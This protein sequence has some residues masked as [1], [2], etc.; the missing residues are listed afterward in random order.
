MTQARFVVILVVV[1]VSA[2]TSV[3]LAYVLTGSPAPIHLAVSENPI[4]GVIS[5]N[6][7]GIFSNASLVREFEA[8][9]YANQSGGPASTLTLQV[10][11]ETYDDPG[12]GVVRTLVGLTLAGHFASA[13][14]P[15]NLLLTVNDTGPAI[16]LQVDSVLVATNFTFDS[17]PYISLLQASTGSLS[18]SLTNAGSAIP[19]YQFGIQSTISGDTFEVS[20]SPQYNHFVGFRATVTGPFTPAVSVSVL[21]EIINT[22]GG[23]WA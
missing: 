14:G 19:F 11:T 6:L 13:L 7:T 16:S 10:R 12:N 5:G 23:T 9:T 20:F 2:S 3:A 22:N 4:L 8:I 15:R 1:L 21:L 18:A 17:D